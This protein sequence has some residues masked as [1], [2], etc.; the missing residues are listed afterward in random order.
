MLWGY[1]AILSEMLGKFFNA[2]Y[3]LITKKIEDV[4]NYSKDQVFKVIPRLLYYYVINP[5]MNLFV[6]IKNVIYELIS[7]IINN[8]I[9]LFKML[10]DNLET[11]FRKVY[12]KISVLSICPLSFILKIIISP[13]YNL[14]SRVLCIEFIICVV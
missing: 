4:I 13:K 14:L 11:I 8:G 12:V 2:A 6:E 5:I 10:K 9:K 1:R 3:N 7:T